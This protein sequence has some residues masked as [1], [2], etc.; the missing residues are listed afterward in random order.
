MPACKGI[1]QL[2]YIVRASA[3][4]RPDRRVGAKPTGR[5]R[6]NIMKSLLARAFCSYITLY[7]QAQERLPRYALLRCRYEGLKTSGQSVK[8][9]R[10]DNMWY[11]GG[12][13]LSFRE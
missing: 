5:A 11:C 3:E 6:Y 10:N 8:G 2:Y 4:S 12:Y 1:L 7:E 9:V 13:S